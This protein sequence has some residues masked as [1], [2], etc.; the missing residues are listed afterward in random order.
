MEQILDLF[1]KA[2]HGQPGELFFFLQSRAEA[3]EQLRHGKQKSCEQNVIAAVKNARKQGRQRVGCIGAGFAHQQLIVL[4]EKVE[5]TPPRI[6]SVIPFRLD[7]AVCNGHTRDIGNEIIVEGQ[8]LC[9]I[10]ITQR[11]VRHRIKGKGR[12]VFQIQLGACDAEFVLCVQIQLLFT[13]HDEAAGIRIEVDGRGLLLR[14]VFDLR[15]HSCVVDIDKRLR[16]DA[17]HFPVPA[18]F[19]RN[20]IRKCQY[21]TVCA[22]QI[23]DP[24]LD[25]MVAGGRIPAMRC[26]QKTD[27]RFHIGSPCGLN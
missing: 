23:A 8:M 19:I 22:V 15:Q 7:H 13:D 3:C 16:R 27:I 17:E 2:F 5:R 1:V 9:R 18:V 21:F 10:G 11:A 14:I 12:L 4:C 25:Q 26:A 6:G 24:R 20:G